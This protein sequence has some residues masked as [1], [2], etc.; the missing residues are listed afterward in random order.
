VPLSNFVPRGFAFV[1]HS[2]AI[3][4]HEVPNPSLT[5]RDF[6]IAVGGAAGAAAGGAAVLELAAALEAMRK[7]RDLFKAAADAAGGG[8]G[9][10]AFAL[11]LRKQ[12]AHRG[13]KSEWSGLA[14]AGGVPKHGRAVSRGIQLCV[15]AAHPLTRTERGSRS[16]AELPQLSYQARSLPRSLLPSLAGG[17]GD[18]DVKASV[19]GLGLKAAGGGGG[20]AASRA[21]TDLVGTEEF[22]DRH[23]LEVQLLECLHEQSKKDER[24]AAISDDVERYKSLLQ[25]AG[26]VR[27]CAPSLTAPRPPYS[28]M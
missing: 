15:L 6:V 12:S 14:T 21:G 27:R 25:Q 23:A 3:L 22:L 24:L 18:I 1:H 7:E 19:L 13:L 17:G 8:G 16:D 5:I 4:S 28:W 20:G 2:I 26:D 11:R 10:G 9:A